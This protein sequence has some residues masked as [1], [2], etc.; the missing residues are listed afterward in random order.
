MVLYSVSCFSA[1]RHEVNEREM[2]DCNTF[3]RLARVSMLSV[4]SAPT[5]SRKITGISAFCGK[6]THQKR[7]TGLLNAADSKSR[8]ICGTNCTYEAEYVTRVH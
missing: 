1:N 2:V 7:G 3:F 4:G 8:K 5:E 6:R